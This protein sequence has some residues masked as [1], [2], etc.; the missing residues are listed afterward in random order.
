MNVQTIQCFY[1]LCP[2]HLNKQNKCNLISC[3]ALGKELICWEQRRQQQLKNK[4]T[5]N[6]HNSDYRQTA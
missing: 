1:D 4:R 6:P 3:V 5:E 2:H